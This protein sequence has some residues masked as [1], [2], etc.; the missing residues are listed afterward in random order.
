VI[1]SKWYFEPLGARSGKA[2]ARER[3]ESGERVERD[4]SHT[5]SRGVPCPEA[6]A[7]G[8]IS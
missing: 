1:V 7:S 5:V 2:T 8:K 6:A 3:D 4:E